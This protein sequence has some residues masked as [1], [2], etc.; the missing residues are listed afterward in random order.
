MSNY[1]SVS[2][3]AKARDS[4]HQLTVS[5]TKEALQC[6]SLLH[7]WIGEKNISAVLENSYDD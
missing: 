6:H 7:K 3:A 2:W 1:V 4:L 5:F